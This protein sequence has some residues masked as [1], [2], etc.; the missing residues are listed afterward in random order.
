M[1]YE[2]GIF[3]VARKMRK[4]TI[5]GEEDIYRTD[6]RHY[7]SAAAFADGTVKVLVEGK[8]RGS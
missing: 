8:S 6:H 3:M 2:K 1:K 5:L 4:K 7:H